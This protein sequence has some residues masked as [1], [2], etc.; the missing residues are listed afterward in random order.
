VGGRSSGRSEGPRPIGRTFFDCGVNLMGELA[1]SSTV[2]ITNRSSEGFAAVR[3][4]VG[5]SIILNM[6]RAEFG[7]VVGH[8]GDDHIAA[9]L[10]DFGPL[11]ILAL[12]GILA[13]VRSFR[14]WAP[15]R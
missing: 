9:A 11:G 10:R 1:R 12:L 7:R 5:C 4:V 13:G 6:R 2:S 14:L 15:C 8:F 3:S